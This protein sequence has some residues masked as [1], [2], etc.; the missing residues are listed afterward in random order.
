MTILPPQLSR[1]SGA[2]E[3][4]AGTSR[5]LRIVLLSPKGPLYRHRGGIFGKGLRYMPLTLPT[6]AA[7]IPQDLPHELVCYDEGIQDI[8]EDLTADIVGITVITGTAPR[9]YEHAAR[10][11]ARGIAVVMGG[12]HPTLIPDDVQPHADS[13]VVGYAEDE[14]PRLLRDFV[15]GAMRPRYTAQPGL[16]IGGRPLPRREVLPARRYLTQHVF[17]ATRGCIHAC[18][19]C[20]V[21]AAWPGRPLQKPPEE[22]VAD[23]LRNRAR[24]ALF[25]DLNISA[26]RAYALTLFGALKPLG[27]Q[28]FGLSTT[29]LVEDQELLD[30]AAA[31]GCRGLLMGLESIESSALKGMRK[32]FNDPERYLVV[33]ERLH[34]RGSPCRAASS[35]ETTTNDRT[36]S[37]APRASPSR[38]ASTCRGSPSSR[39][40]PAPASTTALRRKDD[41]CI[42]S[43]SSMTGSTSS[44]GRS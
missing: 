22:I 32:G 1:R 43:G 21:P 6:L 29:L 34:E 39:P 33:V 35:S 41:C 9:A 24:R 18:D 40:F 38:S 2:A 3:P 28:W 37:C 4:G 10:L 15:A 8:P 7:L 13:V 14:W 17:E 42:A 19:F 23:I 44:S 36:S 20:V 25:V 26:D 16:R 5:P 12:P 30:A 11:R 27:I 31:S